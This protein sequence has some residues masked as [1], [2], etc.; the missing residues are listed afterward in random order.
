MLVLDL[1]S[2]DTDVLV[3]GLLGLED[4]D[5]EQYLAVRE[6]LAETRNAMHAATADTSD[7][8]VGCRVRG[9]FPNASWGEGVVTVND[10]MLVVDGE[11]QKPLTVRRDDG[12]VGHFHYNQIEQVEMGGWYVEL[13][14]LA[15]P[16]I[17]EVD[18][19]TVSVASDFKGRESAFV[20][21]PTRE[22][23]ADYV[24]ANYPD[25]TADIESVAYT[26][27]RPTR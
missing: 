7:L 24:R 20:Y 2:H 3:D 22:A 5:E 19:I 21:G 4:A 23:V 16:I 26:A 10:P 9:I 25:R 17:V 1:L 13:R 14:D 15:T 18:G 8:P 6:L 12:S 11:R 27:Y